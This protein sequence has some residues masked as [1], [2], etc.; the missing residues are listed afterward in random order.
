MA[1]SIEGVR[2]NEMNDWIG[3]VMDSPCKPPREVVEAGKNLPKTAN[4]ITDGDGSNSTAPFLTP[5]HAISNTRRVNLVHDAPVASMSPMATSTRS[6]QGVE[7]PASQAPT[8]QFGSSSHHSPNKIPVMSH[9]DIIIGVVDENG[10]GWRQPHIPARSLTRLRTP[11]PSSRQT[12]HPSLKERSKTNGKVSSPTAGLDETDQVAQTKPAEKTLR[13]SSIP[14]STSK[15]ALVRS[16][17]EENTVD[18]LRK[19]D[20]SNVSTEA[21]HNHASSGC[22]QSKEESGQKS[23]A[24]T[25]RV[26][27]SCR[28]K[29]CAK[30]NLVSLRT[31]SEHLRADV[32]RQNGRKTTHPCTN[33]R[34]SN[35]DCYKS[36]YKSC[37]GCARRKEVCSLSGGISKKE[38][39]RR[40]RVEMNSTGTAEDARDNSGSISEG[41]SNTIEEA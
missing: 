39:L 27:C 11:L 32:I 30:G 24:K 5:V 14:C 20:W 40:K 18:Q 23:K 21:K 34:K 35:R 16:E 6:Q 7:F 29:K 3:V 22:Q 12:S 33:C 1:S 2:H 13:Q 25:K 8:N 9:E 15:T 28:D 37:D 19:D 38:Q 36:T 17:S 41:S 4:S 26:L 10:R 31:Q